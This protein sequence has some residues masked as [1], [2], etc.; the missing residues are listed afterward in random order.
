MS[1]MIKV[2]TGYRITGSIPGQPPRL[3]YVSKR[4]GNKITI[5]LMNGIVT[6]M[7]TPAEVFGREY[8]QVKT[9]FGVYNLSPCGEVK[10]LN[11]VAEV[12]DIIRQ[13]PE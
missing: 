5:M 9:P 4:V 12:C 7:V 11:E 13:C 8:A 10:D 6:C 1:E 2:N 3:A